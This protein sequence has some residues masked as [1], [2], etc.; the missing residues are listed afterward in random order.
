MDKNQKLKDFIKKLNEEFELHS[1]E[2]WAKRFVDDDDEYVRDNL[3]LY[4]KDKAKCIEMVETYVK[5]KDKRGEKELELSLE[6]LSKST[7]SALIY[8]YT[9]LVNEKQRKKIVDFMLK[10]KNT[11]GLAYMVN[12]FSDINV[13][14]IAEQVV[15]TN[16]V[17]LALNFFSIVDAKFY[18][19]IASVEEFIIANGNLKQMTKYVAVRNKNN[20]T[21]R[22]AE[23]G[24]LERFSVKEIFELAESAITN[25]DFDGKL[26]MEGALK[27]LNKEQS[28]ELIN[29]MYNY[30]QNFKIV[31]IRPYI[32]SLIEADDFDLVYK[33]AESFGKREDVSSYI[34]PKYIELADVD[35]LLKL[36][37]LN[38]PQSTIYDSQI[39]DVVVK[40]GTAS[41]I[42]NF[43]KSTP[44]LFDGNNAKLVEEMVNAL[45]TAGQSENN[46]EIIVRF[47]EEFKQNV[48]YVKIVSLVFDANLNA[49]QTYD[50]AMMAES[51]FNGSYPELVDKIEH[52]LIATC[53]AEDQGVI[54]LQ[55]AVKFKQQIN[56]DK[57]ILALADTSIESSVLMKKIAGDNFLEKIV[58]SLDLSA[59]TQFVIKYIENKKNVTAT[60]IIN[61]YDGVDVGAVVDKIIEM[62]DVNNAIKL[63]DLIDKKH[64]SKTEKLEDY[65][66]A[67]SDV[68]L[69]AYFSGKLSDKGI[70]NDK[71][72][73]RIIEIGSTQEIFDVA[74]QSY[75]TDG[76][77]L[78][79]HLINTVDQGKIMGM[80][81]KYEEEG[82]TSFPTNAF[83][84]I[85]DT[86]NFELICAY[87]KK[88]SHYEGVRNA[89]YWKYVEAEDT[90]KLYKL[91]SLGVWAGT[92][93]D[94]KFAKLMA[95]SK[96]ADYISEYMLMSRLYDGEHEEVVKELEDALIATKD[97]NAMVKVAHELG[98]KVD[99]QKIKD[100]VYDTGNQECIDAIN[101]L[102]DGIKA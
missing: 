51:A 90:E 81:E 18:N 30:N 26:I 84:A 15:R 47:A 8:S 76:K 13:K 17:E 53:V 41:Q 46:Y 23:V 9:D 32:E 12:K 75:H 74:V 19:D 2:G 94:P 96:N 59:R 21:N 39:A 88:F 97:A 40:F 92:E 14:N 52:K 6:E 45:V 56:Y 50:L 95:K 34:F 44:Y 28:L 100:A 63:F 31:P 11:K 16:D 22:K 5:N 80:I 67:N 24:M 54:L 69:L 89:V 3:E 1:K 85:L 25:S 38:M 61:N 48:D 49:G 10:N 7:D 102:V 70:H 77:M 43:M 87:T 99:L 82:Y 20:I 91:K 27:R 79:E 37:K 58:N 68:E 4:N 57:M 73:K 98:E 42:L 33:F 66:I 65:I 29:K 62:G 101:E 36:R 64:Y 60:K 35:K 72:E 71:V 93:M 83:K 78:M 86:D 55:F